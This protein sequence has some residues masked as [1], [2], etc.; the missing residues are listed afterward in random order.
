MNDLIQGHAAESLIDLARAEDFTD[1]QFLD[2][3]AETERERDLIERLKGPGAHLLE[4]PRGVGKSSLLK[5]AEL[6]LDDGFSIKRTIGVYVN[7]K[8]SLLVESGRSELGYD[9]FLCWV[10]A[11]ILDAFYKKCRKLQFITSHDIDTR[12]KRLLGVNTTWT[13]SALEDSIRDLQSLAVAASEDARSD[14]LSKLSLV[15]LQQF[16]NIETVAEFVKSIIQ[17]AGLKRINFLFDEAAHTFDEQQQEAFFQFFKLLHGGTI[18]VKAATYPGITSYGGNFEIG[19]D[20]V[21]LSI[22]STQENLEPSQA[23]LRRHFRVL[24]GKRISPSQFRELSSRGEALDLLILLSHGNPRI[25]L[26]TISKWVATKEYSKRSALAASNEFVSSELVS[27]HMGLKKRLPRFSA[28]IDLGMALVTAH[29]VPEL[30]KK[31]EGKGPDPK[32]QSVYFTVD[33]TVHFKVMKALSLLEYSGY[34][35]SKSVVKTAGRKQA[36][37]FAMHLGVAANEKVFHS[38]LSRDPDIVIKRLSIADYREFYA[39]DSRFDQLVADHPSTD[40]CPNNHRRQID[41]AFC[42]IC[43]ERF[44]VDKV[45]ETLRDDSVERLSLTDFLKS[46]LRD[47]FLAKDIRSVL[48]LTPTRL[49]TAWMIGPVRARQIVNAAEE[50]ISG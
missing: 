16:A 48:K 21:K 36:R 50:Y 43:G 37:R 27:Y 23:E 15:G 28:H 46:K 4:G 40:T 25:F 30:Q 29:L 19:Q 7:F 5:K 10:A 6:E 39:S 47:D 22:S 24:L 31:N 49:Q 11:K 13:A 45:I 26:Q 38:T 35:F 34:I 2:C 9:P 14:I 32:V 18:A 3:F 42:P 17:H 20:A 33:P 41:G 12:Y 8:A 44:K 1:E